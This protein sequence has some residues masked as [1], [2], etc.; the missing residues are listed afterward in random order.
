MIGTVSLGFLCE[1]SLDSLLQTWSRRQDDFLR[2]NARMLANSALKAWNLYSVFLSSDVPDEAARKGIITIE[3][4]FRA[5]TEI[6]LESF[7]KRSW[8]RRL[9]EAVVRPLAPMT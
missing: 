7:R 2:S 1:L 3:E 4:D 6:I 8:R 5:S 9:M